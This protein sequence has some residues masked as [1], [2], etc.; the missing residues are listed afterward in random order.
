M[1][2]VT[3]IVSIS[4]A[5]P[6][7]SHTITIRAT[8]NCGVTTDATFTLTVD[9]VPP[10]T[11]YVDDSWVGTPSGGDPD[12][13][14]PAMSFGCDSFATIQDAVNGVA[15]R[16]A[17]GGNSPRSYD[18]CRGPVPIQRLSRSTKSA[19]YWA[20]KPA[21]TRTR[22]LPRSPPDR[23]DRRSIRAVES[24]ITAAAT[25]PASAAND[26]LHIMADDVTID[27]FVIDGTT[28]R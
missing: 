14:G 10:S 9:C 27:G 3:G 15:G 2:N 1:D 16:P 28:R 22:D 24:I 20:P 26:T 17:N 12:G 8:D 25:A 5:A 11:V 18:H 21:R 6:V 19:S 7:G 4:N 13:A 23:T